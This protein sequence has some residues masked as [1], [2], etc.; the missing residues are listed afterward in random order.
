MINWIGSW[1]QGIVIAVVISTIIEM[2]LPDGNIKKYVRTVIGVYIVFVIISP[3]ITKITGKCNRY[4]CIY[5]KY[6]H[7]QTKTRH[8]KKDRGKRI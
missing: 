1:V 4:K 6:I 8:N 7:K 2:I 3:I 5:R